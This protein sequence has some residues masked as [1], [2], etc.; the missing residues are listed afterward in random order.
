[1][2][3]WPVRQAQCGPANTPGPARAAHTRR[4]VPPRCRRLKGQRLIAHGRPTRARPARPCRSQS[5]SPT[6]MTPAFLFSLVTPSGLGLSVLAG[7]GRGVGLGSPK[8]Q[9]FKFLLAHHPTEFPERKEGNENAKHHDAASGEFIETDV[10]RSFCHGVSMDQPFD[11]F[12]DHVKSEN[13]ERKYEGL[14]NR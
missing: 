8:D 4:A 13:Q 7:N 5:R 3:E 9:G 2:P 11:H 12:L 1:M 14:P 10:P 6:T